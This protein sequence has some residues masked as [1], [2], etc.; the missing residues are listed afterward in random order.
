MADYSPH[1]QRIIR[2]YY[3][4]REGMALQKLQE[5]VSD[6]YLAESQKQS[7]RLWKRIEKAMSNLGVPPRI[8]SHVL[9]ERKVEILAEHVKV[10]W[11][12]PPDK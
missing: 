1:Q 12:K 7:D 2:S 8:A 11:D 9:A 10:W 3:K 5:L 6:L 4:N